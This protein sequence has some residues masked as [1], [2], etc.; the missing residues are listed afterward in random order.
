MATGA[1]HASLL[2]T[3][4]ASVAKELAPVLVSRKRVRSALRNAMADHG[5]LR[6]L[7]QRVKGEVLFASGHWCRERDDGRL[8]QKLPFRKPYNDSSIVGAGLG[9]SLI[10]ALLGDRAELKSAHAIHALGR[11]S[12]TTENELG[13]QNDVA[14]KEVDVDRSDEAFATAREPQHWHRDTNLLWS[15]SSMS[16]ADASQSQHQQRISGPPAHDMHNGFFSPAYAINSFVPLR[17]LHNEDG[18]TEF[19]LGYAFVLHLCST[20]ALCVYGLVKFQLLHNL[21]DNFP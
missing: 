6:S 1:A 14:S 18:P 11:S 4:E 7:W 13:K 10:A 21:L 5:N 12:T 19:T 8:D 17:D 2:D 16:S 15:S 3:V 9:L 20:V